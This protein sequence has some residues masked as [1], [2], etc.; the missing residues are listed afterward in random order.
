MCIIWTS[1]I[2][3][4]SL[5]LALSISQRAQEAS[6]AHTHTNY[7]SLWMENAPKHLSIYQKK[8]N[9]RSLVHSLLFVAAAAAAARLLL[10]MA[11][12]K[13]CQV[14]FTF[15]STITIIIIIVVVVM[16]CCCTILSFYR[17]RMYIYETSVHP[18]QQQQH[19][20]RAYVPFLT[21]HMPPH[22]HPAHS[23]HLLCDILL[24]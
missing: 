16:K 13:L 4:I 18:L 21:S 14:V 10:F 8:K 22:H 23:L 12:W 1:F 19:V 3:P 5:G 2:P 24:Y 17:E 7:E 20:A 6:P 11:G 9:V 15:Y